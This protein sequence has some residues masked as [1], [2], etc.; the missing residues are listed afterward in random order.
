MTVKELRVALEKLEKEG[1][2]SLDVRMG[3]D[4]S[5]CWFNFDTVEEKTS[6]DKESFIGLG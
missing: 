2:D 6:E 3:Q 1:K 5:C 4:C